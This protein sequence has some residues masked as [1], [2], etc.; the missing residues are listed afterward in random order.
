MFDWWENSAGALKLFY[1][2]AIFASVLQLLQLATVLLGFGG[3]DDVTTESHDGDVSDGLKLLSIRTVIAFFVGFG[4][5]GAVFL[6]NE[7]SLGTTIIASV[8]VGLI[9]MAL[10][11][12]VMRALF[13]LR[14]SGTLDLAN[15][16]GCTGRVYVTIPPVNAGSGQVEVMF[17]GR[18]NFLSASTTTDHALPPQTEV[19]IVRVAT[20]NTLVV[21]PVS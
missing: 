9:F 5:T 17:Q 14:S 8:F 6:R 3:H 4:W 21:E 15:A 16:V 13:S 19:R 12:G 10:I 1:G 20:G 18:L 7:N 11:L 2:I